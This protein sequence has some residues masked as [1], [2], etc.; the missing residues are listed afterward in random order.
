VTGSRVGNAFGA[1]L[2][3]A[4][5]GLTP[6]AVHAQKLEVQAELDRT[7]IALGEE[8]T[9]TVTVTADGLALPAVNLPPIAGVE[10][11]RAGES[12]GMSFVNGHIS[13]SVGVAFRLHPHSAGTVTIPPVRVSSGGTSAAS[14]ALTLRV[15]SKVPVVRGRESGG[16]EVF[17]RLTLD[18]NRAYWNQ[19][20][21]ARFTL[22]SRAEL[23]AAPV[24][25]PPDAPGFWTESMGPPRGERVTIDGVPYDAMEI[26]IAY[27]PTRTGKLVIGP[28]RVHLQVVRRENPLNTWGLWTLSDTRV[29]EVTL[30]TDQATVNVEPLPAGAPDG[31]Q[32]AVGEY[33]LGLSV[34][35][36]EVHAGEPVTVVTSI[37]GQGNISSA[38]DPVVTA[39]IPTRS[40]ATGASTKL[41]RSGDRLSGERRH[42]VAFIPE[43]PGQLVV[44]PVRFAWFDPE[45]VRYRAQS[46][47]SITIRVLPPTAGVDSLH[48]ARSVGPLATLRPSGGPPASLSLDA[49]G[50]SR[51]L[52]LG[53]LLAY[54]GVWGGIRIRA[55]MD[56]SPVRMRRRGL[57]MLLAEV[58]RVGRSR[59]VSARPLARA[60][61]ALLEAVALRYQIDVQGRSIKEAMEIARAAGAPDSETEEIVRTL[62]ALERAAFAP[63]L[64]GEEPDRAALQSV[65]SVIRRY[66]TEVA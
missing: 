17:V 59:P 47:D 25:D 2:A 7:D 27:F 15:G 16:G 31:F 43:T 14:Q 32:G 23:A 18:R 24:W 38:G 66:Q 41:D 34:D 26:R 46:S 61:E 37:R 8:A 35:R 5:L 50:A 28:G 20:V 48:L 6:A 12:Q 57:A 9:L 39:S 42:E 22:Y 40:Y 51:A 65:E 60:G 36:F 4:W 3:L 45:E 62:E 30:E 58:S 55:R 21:L 13:R 19:Q 29:Q 63:G 52:A 54:L 53:S 44:L 1:L 56:R 11:T 33:N 49:P 10:I 64:A